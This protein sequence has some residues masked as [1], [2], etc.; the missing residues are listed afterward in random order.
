VLPLV[1][2]LELGGGILLILNRYTRW[3]AFA[4]AAFTLGAGVIGHAFW[5]AEPAQYANHL[6]HF[7]KN[8]AIVGG[9]I[10]V[11]FSRRG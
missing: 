3:V 4:L 7:L 1:I 11:A 10:G 5:N 8:V 9:L 6:N 2:L